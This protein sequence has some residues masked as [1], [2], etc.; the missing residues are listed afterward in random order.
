M[1]AALLGVGVCGSRPV[2]IGRAQLFAREPT[3]V[4][5]EIDPAQIEAEV[6]RLDAALE[7]ARH[8]LESVRGQIP[9]STPLHIAEFIDA[10]LLMLTDSA[11]VDATRDLIRERSINAGWALQIQ[12]DTLVEVFDAMGDAYLRTRRDDVDHVVRQIQVFLSGEPSAQS[13]S[14]SD[15]KD[16]VIVAD[17]LTPADTILLRHRGIC[18]F[19]IE[20]GGPMS[21]T[22]ILARSLDIPA[23]LGV[24]NA[25]HLLRQDELLVVNAE[26]GTVLAGA[27]E[28]ILAHYRKR[29]VSADQRRHRLR[30]LVREP[31]TSRDGVPV[32]LLAN[33]ELPEDVDAVRSSGASG[34]GLY[35]TEF[36]YMNR[37]GLPDEEEHLETYLGV[38]RGLDGIPLTIRTL[39]LG[40]DKQV[41]GLAGSSGSLTNPAL[42][43]RAIRL[44]LREPG[45][46]VPQLRAILRASAHGPVRLMLPMISAIAEVETVLG[47]I[48]ETRRTLRRQGL[49]FDPLMPVG[50]MIEVP[51]AAL[52]AGGIAKRVD[53]LSIGTNDLIQYT[54]A[55]D[56]VD[57][58]VNYLYDPLHPAVLRLIRIT[59]SRAAESRTRVSM[60][61]EM[62]GDPRYTAIL[63]GLGLR[64][65]SM[66]PASLLEVKE[67]VRSCDVGRV[68]NR[69]DQLM[70]RLDDLTSAQLLDAVNEVAND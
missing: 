21:H 63:L 40:M 3:V 42:G 68:S 59:L 8:H 55:I 20:H 38:M 2:A 30:E 1:T 49:P 7:C 36:L 62:A 37:S 4:T 6:A 66:Q 45:L 10:H 23:V 14:A 29:L 41:D 46:F 31:S 34:V 57:D 25:T 22:A 44:C 32:V 35:R 56:R 17:D 61:G 27:D 26:S 51:A 70:D 43:L 19:V 64:E 67:V 33:L 48:A 53:F 54:L 12:R 28:S 58:S 52:C 24:H 16:R 18:A 5:E 60:C 15:L 65:M 13:V 47:M 9:N 69:M 39:D 50:A 11:L